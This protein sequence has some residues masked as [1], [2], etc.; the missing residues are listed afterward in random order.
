M[1]TWIFTVPGIP[2]TYYGDEF[3]L[4]GANDPDN[5]RPMKFEGLNSL[6]QKKPIPLYQYG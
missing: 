4:P 5:R 3:G 1:H 6:E 2:V